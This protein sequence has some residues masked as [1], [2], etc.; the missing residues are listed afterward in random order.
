[1]KM[2]GEDHDTANAF[3]YVCTAKLMLYLLLLLAVIT[4]CHMLLNLFPTE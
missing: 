4:V 1:M 3:L 2:L